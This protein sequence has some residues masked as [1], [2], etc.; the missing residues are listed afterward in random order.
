MKTNRSQKESAWIELFLSIIRKAYLGEKFVYENRTFN[1]EPTLVTPYDFSRKIR[2]P[3]NDYER[4]LVSLNPSFKAAARAEV[5]RRKKGWV[6]AGIEGYHGMRIRR[7]TMNKNVF[8]LPVLSQSNSVGI[9]TS[10]IENNVTILAFC[11][12]PDHEAAYTYLER[13]MF[14]PKTHDHPEFKWAKL[15]QNYRMRVLEKLKMLLAISC[16]AILLIE[17]DAIISPQG[18]FENLFRNLI[19]GCFSGYERHP[20]Q[21]KLRLHLR[22][23]LFQLANNVQVHCDKDFPHLTSDKA[24]KLF[25][26]TLAKRNGWYEQYTPLYAPLKSHESKPIQVADI[27]VGALKTKIQNNEP[28]EPL[29]PLPFDKRKIA[30]FKGRYAKAY[31]WAP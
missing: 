24:V 11:F 15:N 19:E 10:S 20:T 13:H 30:A 6:A 21:S 27:I 28:L 8:L 29:S 31:H 17:T 16:D 4:L 18:K 1:L 22:K 12:I 14:L 5:Y 3:K 25:V 23:K 26:Q 7:V 2:H 9:D